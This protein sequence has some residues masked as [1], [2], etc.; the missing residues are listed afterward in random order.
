[1]V[2]GANPQHVVETLMQ[3]ISDWNW[4]R[5]HELYAEEAVIEYPFALPAPRRIQGRA[6]RERRQ[7]LGGREGLH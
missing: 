4:S 3:G 7:G 6:A 1:M 5:L 2:E